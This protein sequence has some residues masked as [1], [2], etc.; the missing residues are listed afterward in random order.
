MGSAGASTLPKDFL[1]GFATASYQIEGAVAEDGR[2]PSIWDTFCKIPGKIADG[3]NGD[4]A[5]D[6]YHRV[7]EDIALLK[8]CG[9][10]AY[11]FSI[12]W[13]RIIPLG[14]RNDPINQKGL[15]HY[16]AFIDALH[17]A[18]IV[19]LVTLYHWDLPD[20]LDQRYG[21]LLNKEE[22]VADFTRYARVLFEAFGARV[23]HWITFNEPWCS[24]VLGY[25]VGQFAPGRTSDRAKSRVGDGAREPW[26]VGHN[27][28]VAH[29]A[30]VKVYREEFK[31]RDGGEIGITLNGDWAEPW[32]PANPADVEAC[33][34]KIEFAISWFADPIYHG[35]Y[36]DS[37]V[38]QL[39]DRLPAWTAEDRALVHG[40]NDFYGMNH[41]CAN[42][43]RAKTGAPDPTDTA[44]NLEILLQN[45][46]GE[47]IGPETQSAWLRPCAL[48]FR[49][50]LKWLSD[51]YGQPKIYVTENGTSLKGEND[52]PVDQLLRDEFRVQYFR[53]YIAAMA[54]A[55]TL[56]GVDVRAYMAWSLMDNFEWAE[57]YETRFGVTYV[58]Y[59]NGQKRLPKESAK[60]I[61]KIFEQY[62]EKE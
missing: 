11:R 6:S 43:I 41:Y 48:G 53:D 27:L 59:E 57:G 42:Y 24:A 49:K 15:D 51:R 35:K 5:C 21:G 13:S 60:Q 50:L 4:V 29:G 32:D 2:G 38:R 12:S 56:D 31:G 62:I 54:D 16:S 33:T 3:S 22:F 25:N 34:R 14:G 37:M 55:Y 28:L 40:S 19:P 18:G 8:Q 7:D 47:W 30:A 1:W 39:G 52:L 20:A 46:A 9:A 36:P 23:R 61:G 45:K 58:D 10:K 17:A 26:I 44:G